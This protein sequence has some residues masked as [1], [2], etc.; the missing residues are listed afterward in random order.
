M[1]G[2]KTPSGPPATFSGPFPE[3][4]GPGWPGS[5]LVTPSGCSRRPSLFGFHLPIKNF[6]VITRCARYNAALLQTKQFNSSKNTTAL[7]SL[8]LI[9]LRLQFCCSILFILYIYNCGAKAI[10]RARGTF[11]A[12]TSTAPYC[13]NC[14]FM[15]VMVQVL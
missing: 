7:C 12:L 2:T 3:V 6:V 14:I 11:V 15:L 4:R 8:H 5:A 1:R 13:S 10:R 9:E